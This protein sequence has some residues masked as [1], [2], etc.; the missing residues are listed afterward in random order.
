[1]KGSQ[2]DPPPQK[3]LPSNSKSPAL[4]GL[5]GGFKI[6]LICAVYYQISLEGYRIICVRSFSFAKGQAFESI[7][8][9]IYVYIHLHSR[10]PKK[11][12]C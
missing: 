12:I 8:Q 1:M 2:I 5:T 10:S 4:L 7:N 3:K 9:S 6:T 11:N